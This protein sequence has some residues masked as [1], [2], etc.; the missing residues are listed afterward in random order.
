MKTTTYTY[1][2][3]P[4]YKFQVTAAKYTP[5]RPA[6]DGVTLILAHGNATHKVRKRHR[7]CVLHCTAIK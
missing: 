1:D 7:T 5:D 4:A 3:R 6:A 2:P